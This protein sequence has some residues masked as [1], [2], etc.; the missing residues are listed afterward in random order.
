MISGLNSNH[1][2][3]MSY[4]PHYFGARAHGHT[5][6]FSFLSL[7]DNLPACR[8]YSDCLLPL[9]STSVQF[10]FCS[11]RQHQ[12]IPNVFNIMSCADTDVPQL[13]MGLYPGKPTVSRECHKSEMHLI[14]PTYQTS[15]LS[16][17]V[18]YQ[19]F[20][21]VIAWLTE[22]CSLLPLHHKGIYTLPIT[23]LG[24]VQNLKYGFY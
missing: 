6:F 14:H 2:R 11:V 23:S 9:F 20:S 5:S 18:E 1:T 16:N 21:L 22:S 8:F 17:T 19:L 12:P 10:L 4:V 24:K 7:L 13:M 3:Q 15:Q